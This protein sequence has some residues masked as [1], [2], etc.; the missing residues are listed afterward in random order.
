MF[1]FR[2]CLKIACFQLNDDTAFA[3][4]I[5]FGSNGL[6]VYQ[7]FDK[8]GEYRVGLEGQIVF[9]ALVPLGISAVNDTRCE[10]VN[11]NCSLLITTDRAFFML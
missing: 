2:K 4:F 1:A 9:T 7:H 11:G 5:V 6:T 8:V 10:L 3:L